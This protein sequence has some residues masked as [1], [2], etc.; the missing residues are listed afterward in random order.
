MFITIAFVVTRWTIAIIMAISAGAAS[1]CT[2]G[3]VIGAAA[4]KQIKSNK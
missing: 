1:W 2:S 4:G 3:L